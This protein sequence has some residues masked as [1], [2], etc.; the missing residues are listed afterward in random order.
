MREKLKRLSFFFKYFKRYSRRWASGILVTAISTGFAV[1][2]PLIIKRAVDHLENGEPL[3]AILLD[4]LL[5]IGVTIVSGFFRFLMRQTMIVA[6]RKV[7][8]DIRNDLFTHLESLDRKFYENTPTGDI[9]SRSTNDLDAVRAMYGPGI[10]H[11]LSTFFMVTMAFVLMYRIDPVLSLYSMITLPFLSVTVIVLGRQVYKRYLKIQEH[12]GKISAFVQENLSGIRVVQSFVQESNQIGRFDD[13]NKEFIRKNMSMVKIWGMFFPILSM[14]GGGLTVLILL[15]GG[16][17]VINDEI[18]LGTFVAFTAYLLMLIW[19]MIALGW[20]IGLYQRGLASMAR[21]RKIFERKPVI[22]SPGHADKDIKIKGD[23]E[24]RN[25]SF[26]YGED[27][28][29]I[30]HDISFKVKAGQTIAIVG[31]TGSGKT[32]LVSLLSRLYPVPDNKIFIDGTDINTYDLN[33]LRSNIGFIPQDNFLFSDSL[34]GNIIFGS[35]TELSDLEVTTS[36]SNADLTKDVDTFPHKM[37]TIIGEK[38]ITLSGGQ[39]QRT[40][41]ARAIINNPPIL[42]FDDAFSSVDTSTEEKIL[43]N[44]RDILKSSTV[45]LISHRISTVK[46]A[47][48]ILVIDDGKLA[49]SGDHESLLA[50]GGLYANIHKRQ[51][52]MEELEAI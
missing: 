16:K 4:S 41:I 11:S 48:L 8:Y 50:E 9:M 31:A 25:L 20:V 10:M 12:Y 27:S 33:T 39:K 23:I 14:I 22:V 34:K 37:E 5:I 45:F 3:N 47:D 30:L 6:S 7:E 15:V 1:L 43:S 42:I 13:L 28:E 46:D 26:S 18:T 52:L 38:G 24:V 2:T 17:R 51:L 44:L 36:A 49:E 19:P 40:S 21:I 29:E 32:T 35:D